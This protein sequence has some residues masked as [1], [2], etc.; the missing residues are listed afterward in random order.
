MR[1]ICSFGVDSEVELNM[2]VLPEREDRVTLSFEGKN[3]TGTVGRRYFEMR[4]GL[5]R[6]DDVTFDIIPRS[7]WVCVLAFQEILP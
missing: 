4:P 7:E 2:P 1:V 6:V 3:L 5:I